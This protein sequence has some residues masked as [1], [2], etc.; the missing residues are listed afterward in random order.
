MIGDDDDDDGDMCLLRGLVARRGNDV[1]TRSVTSS[2]V[3]SW[4]R[5]ESA[6]RDDYND[7]DDDDVSD[8]TQSPPSLFAQVHLASTASHSLYDVGPRS[9]VIS[10]SVCLSVCHSVC[11]YVS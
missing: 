11:T 1:L 7:D 3:T 2:S 10:L 9:I 8:V 6:P 5:D 4:T